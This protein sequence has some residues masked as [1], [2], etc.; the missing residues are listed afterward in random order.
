MDKNDYS[1]KGEVSNLKC[2]KVGHKLLVCFICTA[3]ECKSRFV[4]PKCLI[5]DAEH[6]K[7][8]NP[9]FKEIST[10]F[11]EFEG[12]KDAN[13]AL[14][15]DDEIELKKKKIEV[16]KSLKE[17]EAKRIVI[18]KNLSDL[19][20]KFLLECEHTL[21]NSFK[22]FRTNF[23]MCIKKFMTQKISSFKSYLEELEEELIRLEVTSNKINV[24]DAYIRSNSMSKI[25][26]KMFKEKKYVSKKSLSQEEYLQTL[27]ENLINSGE[28]KKKCNEFFNNEIENNKNLS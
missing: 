22:A 25:D 11:N 17:F 21:I 16:Q 12:K 19:S 5:L 10:F 23:D 7:I 28:G 8:H 13:L 15:E 3:K 27:I 26:D 2:E 9:Q 18:E 4:C 6:N 14:V 24:R 20:S 1:L